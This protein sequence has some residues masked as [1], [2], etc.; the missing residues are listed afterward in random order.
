MLKAQCY[1]CIIYVQLSLELPRAVNRGAGFFL[2][3]ALILSPAVWSLVYAC[4]VEWLV[5]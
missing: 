2:L 3:T 4:S 5:C 1:I